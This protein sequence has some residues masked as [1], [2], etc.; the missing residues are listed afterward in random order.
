[1][2]ELGAA[3]VIVGT[4]AF[5]EPA[6]LGALADAF[7][8]QIA[9]GIDARD[10]FVQ[11]RGWVETTPMT[12]LDLATQVDALGIR[13]L[14]VTDTA[15]DGM[16]AGVNADGIAAVCAAVSCTVIASGGVSSPADVTKLNAIGCNNLG[17]AIVGKALYDGTVSLKDLM[18][19]G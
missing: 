12:A 5:T 10:G 13:T 17:G 1:M 15:T 19:A 9:V 11:V 3:R 8:D 2:L 18:A 7:G 4:R 6:A 14:I 16:L